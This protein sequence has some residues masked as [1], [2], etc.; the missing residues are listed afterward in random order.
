MHSAHFTDYHRL[1]DLLGFAQ[2][3]GVLTPNLPRV[4]QL[5]RRI[6]GSGSGVYRYRAA[7]LWHRLARRALIRTG[8]L[9]IGEHPVG[10]ELDLTA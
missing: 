10:Y 2:A 9:S 6:A 5:L 3:E 1:C 7:R 4:D 8:R